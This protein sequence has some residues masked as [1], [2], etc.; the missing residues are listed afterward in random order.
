V[1]LRKCKSWRDALIGAEQPP[2][3]IR[4]ITILAAMQ[5]HDV[6][7]QLGGAVEEFADRG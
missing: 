2:D 7:R 6:I 4:T 3:E 1:L 5:Q